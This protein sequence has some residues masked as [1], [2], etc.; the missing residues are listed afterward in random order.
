MIAASM[1]GT[2][3]MVISVAAVVILFWLAITVI[4]ALN[5]YIARNRIVTS[6]DDPNHMAHP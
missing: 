4:R 5:V 3:Y 2:I 1:F 6:Q